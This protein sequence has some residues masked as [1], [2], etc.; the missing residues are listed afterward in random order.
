LKTAT[1]KHEILPQVF[2]LN[3]VFEYRF[4]HQHQATQSVLSLPGSRT[5]NPKTQPVTV[6]FLLYH[7]CFLPVPKSSR[8]I[9]VL[10]LV[11]ARPLLHTSNL[12]VIA[13]D[14]GRTL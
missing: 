6:S 12:V 14:C 13:F 5:M 7:S 10:S 2:G 1:G 8:S 4:E 11:L 9:V 3:L